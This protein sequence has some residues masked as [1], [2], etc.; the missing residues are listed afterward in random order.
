MEHIKGNEKPKDNRNLILRQI[1]YRVGIS[2]WTFELDF[3][4]GLSSLDL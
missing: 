3:R 4:V 1:R 2:N